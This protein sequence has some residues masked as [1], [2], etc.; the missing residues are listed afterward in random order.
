MKSKL[1]Q[2]ARRSSRRMFLRGAAATVV[3][4]PL[5][6]FML[7]DDGTALADG[8]TFPCRYLCFYSPTS[9]APSGPTRPDGL[10]PQVEGRGFDF[11][12]CLQP[13]SERGLEAEV[14]AISGLFAAPF[15]APGGYLADYH[16]LADKAIMSGMRSG[17]AAEN[18]RPQGLSADQIIAQAIGDQTRFPSLVYQV[19]PERASSGISYE[20]NTSGELWYVEAQTSP[21]QAYRT[22]FTG[23]APAE[24]DPTAELERRLR[25][26]SLSYAADQIQSLQRELGAADRLRLEEHLTRVRSLEM[27]LADTTG[28]DAPSCFDPMH[29][30]DDPADLARTVPDQTARAALFAELI[31]L[32]FACDMT[33]SISICGSNR[34]TGAGMRHQ[35]WDHIGGLH[36]DVQHGSSQ[37]DLDDANR[38]FVEQ[39]ATIL[40]GL[41][42][43]PEAD[44]TVLDHCAAVFAME[45]GR[46]GRMA[47]NGSDPNHS[48]DNMVYLLA[49]RAGGLSPGQHIR[50]PDQHP[51]LVMTTAMR[52]LGL[53]DQLGEI[54]GS[55]DALFTS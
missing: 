40:A 23:F 55:F 16:G 9:L 22:L 27:Q 43:V 24:P 18:W 36:A 38:W 7:N 39:Y 48:T 33:R 15:D 50:R 17:W 31:Q 12:Y 35:M 25:V 19:D 46:D 14:S 44:G 6:E 4:L 28:S 8:T 53:P 29:P 11:N 26:S 52:A 21:A 32:A 49:G 34:L 2:K 13:L 30:M 5:M 3:S 41:A 10:T 47:D 45:G 54:S 42:A 37:S 51:S 1:T 20:R